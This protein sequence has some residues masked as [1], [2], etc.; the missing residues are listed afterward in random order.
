M[1]NQNRQIATPVRE[2]AAQLFGD[3]SQPTLKG[4]NDFAD[5]ADNKESRER[6]GKALRLTF[7]AMDQATDGAHIAAGAGPISISTGGV[8]TWLQNYFHVP[9]NIAAQQAGMMQDAIK[10]LTPEEQRA[11]DATMSAFGTIVGLRSLTRASAAQA[12]VATIEREMPVLGVNSTSKAQF[13][14]QMARLAE[15]VYNGTKGLPPGTLSPDLVD[16][17]KGQV[18]KS[19]APSPNGK[20]SGPAKPISSKAEYDALPKGAQYIDSD[21]KPYIKK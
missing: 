21:G 4:L 11:Y 12:S 3:P 15:I 7:A 1:F 10:D 2:A 14:D 19:S 13:N 18:K 16:R 8:G 5:L 20:L 6:L 9:Q 17:I